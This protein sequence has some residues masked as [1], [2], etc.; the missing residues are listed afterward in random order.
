MHER[1]MGNPEMR[2]AYFETTEAVLRARPD[3]RG[4]EEILSALEEHRVVYLH[5]RETTKPRPRLDAKGR[6]YIGVEEI[7]QAAARI[8]AER[9]ETRS[10]LS[11]ELEPD[12]GLEL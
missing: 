4:Y 11:Q 5:S 2:K 6:I 10:S 1:V 9:P 8:A 3:H 7:T 12:A